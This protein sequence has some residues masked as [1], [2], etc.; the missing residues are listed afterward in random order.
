MIQNHSGSGDNVAGNKINIDNSIQNTNSEDKEHIVFLIHGIRTTADWAEMVKANIE[1]NSSVTKVKPMGYGYFDIFRFLIPGPWRL[2]PAKKITKELNEL[3]AK[4]SNAKISVLA[5]SFGTFTIS[6][7]LKENHHIK[8]HNL[9]LCGSI[10]PKLFDW[11][12]VEHQILG[13]IIND[14]GTKDFLPVLAQTITSGYGSSG[15]FGFESG[16]VDDRYHELGHSGFFT[17]EFT[18]KFWVPFF[19]DDT[20]IRPDGEGMAV[21]KTPSWWL[22]ILTVVKIWWILPILILLFLIP[23]INTYSNESIVVQKQICENLGSPVD[24]VDSDDQF[25]I[26]ENYLYGKIVPIDEDCSLIWLQIA[27]NNNH[28]EAQYLLSQYFEKKEN[29]DEYLKWLK[30]SADNGFTEAQHLLGE[31]YYYES[32]DDLAIFWLKKSADKNYGKSQLLLGEIYEDLDPP[33]YN[34]AAKWYIL[35]IQNN[36]TEASKNL[37]NIW[38]FQHW[39]PEYPL[40]IMAKLKPMLKDFEYRSLQLICITNREVAKYDGCITLLNID[41]EAYLKEFDS[42]MEHQKNQP[43]QTKTECYGFGSPK[44][45]RCSL[46]N[47][48]NT[49]II[50]PTEKITEAFDSCNK[51]CENI[52]YASCCELEPIHNNNKQGNLEESY[53]C[54]QYSKTSFRL[55]TC[56]DCS[57][58]NV[59][60]LSCKPLNPSFT[61]K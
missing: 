14:C 44:N 56:K 6:H 2:K 10:V 22:Q 60:I 34:E 18:N 41:L 21:R 40:E 23:V 15:R 53:E 39:S 33:N 12:N 17:K 36:V 28:S 13:E 50:Q 49:L 35:A 54:R 57:D 4:Y 48:D 27:A 46:K 59:H 52:D 1:A 19:D 24:V 26:S 11:G 3:R 8:L 7:V 43:I 61:F 16:H 38:N 58:R 42:Y 37:L 47:P 9:C 29:N 55:P 20:I 32:E 25:D 5:H 31:E 51:F 30:K 45:Q